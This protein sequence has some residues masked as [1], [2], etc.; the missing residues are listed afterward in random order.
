MATTTARPQRP[1]PRPD[2]HTVEPMALTEIKPDALYGLKDFCRV[3]PARTGGRL[4]IDVARR[5]AAKGLYGFFSLAAEDASRRQFVTYGRDILAAV[6]RCRPLPT[7]RR[8]TP[9]EERRRARDVLQRL[10]DMTGKPINSA[11]L[12]ETF[13]PRKAVPS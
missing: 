4:S 7:E 2:R 1:K 10:A 13:T 6:A 5:W 3:W 9:A 12:G 11:G 8:P